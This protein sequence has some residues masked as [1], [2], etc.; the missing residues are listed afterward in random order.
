[1]ARL[2]KIDIC[3]VDI[4]ELSTTSDEDTVS[5]IDQINSVKVLK[6]IPDQLLSQNLH[7]LRIAST[8]ICFPQSN[9]EEDCKHASYLLKSLKSKMDVVILEITFTHSRNNTEEVG[10][11]GLSDSTHNEDNL[12]PQQ[13]TRLA[14]LYAATSAVGTLEVLGEGQSLDLTVLETCVNNS[15]TRPFSMA[16]ME[17]SWSRLGVFIDKVDSTTKSK[18]LYHLEEMPTC[19]SGLI[20]PPPQVPN[21]P[22]R[23]KYVLYIHI[24][25]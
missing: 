9:D 17:K 22:S 5:K 10:D 21:T 15:K 11:E 18:P 3:S 16:M 23:S 2:C 14:L 20:K 8:L 13:Y 25:N 6:R 24:R 7:S 19:I 1:M 12:A 4:S